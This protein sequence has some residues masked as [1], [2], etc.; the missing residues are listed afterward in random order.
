M[1]PPSFSVILTETEGDVF[2]EQHWIWEELKTFMAE[3]KFQWAV[4]GGFALDLFLG[5]NIRTHGDLD[6]CV[7]EKD[8][9]TIKNYVLNKGW[10]I[11]E[12]R[13]QGKVRPLE[14]GMLSDPGRNLMCVKDGCDIVKFYPCEDEGMLYH[15]F[16]HTGI[17]GFH[18][19]EFLF[20][21]ESD[22]YL[23]LDQRNS[24]VRELSKAFLTRD[25]I[26]YLAPEIVL[27][28]KASDSENPDYQLDFQETYP[29]LNDEQNAWFFS[30][31]KQLYPNGHG[32][33]Q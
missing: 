32:W 17:N 23:V 14:S 7:L 9:N 22:G 29:Y 8:R 12:F 10:R 18:Y 15:Q 11:Y 33:M 31:M 27:L 16:F 30:A 1:L 24:L 19:L 3:S 13:G 20:N 5:K 21:S 25:G 6:I 26:P 2:M 4:C 28:Y